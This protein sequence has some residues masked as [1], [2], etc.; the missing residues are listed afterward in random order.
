M[1]SIYQKLLRLMG[2]RST[3]FFNK[4]TEVTAPVEHSFIEV[5]FTET[6]DALSVTDNVLKKEFKY[7]QLHYLFALISSSEFK[8]DNS[9]EHIHCEEDSF[10]LALPIN[11]KVL[12]ARF[13]IPESK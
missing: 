8:A 12:A 13:Y 11:G 2:I 3:T 5:S 10:T 1:E 7:I 9:V 4:G 6:Y